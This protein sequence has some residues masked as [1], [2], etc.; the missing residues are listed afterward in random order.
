MFPLGILI[1]LHVTESHQEII[2]TVMALGCFSE[3]LCRNGPKSP[4][5]ISDRVCKGLGIGVCSAPKHCVFQCFPLILHSWECTEILF[6]HFNK[7]E[8]NMLDMV[9]KEF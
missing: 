9:K 5:S 7:F 3:P 2:T 6:E 8:D 1:N 4:V